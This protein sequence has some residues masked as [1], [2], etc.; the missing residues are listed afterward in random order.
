MIMNGYT[1]PIPSSCQSFSTPDPV[2]L[3][4]INDLEVQLTQLRQQIAT[5]VLSQE[6]SPPS[7]G[8][9]CLFSYIFAFQFQN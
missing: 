9:K 6:K 5:I 3:Q 2:A 1:L 8:K 7:N 4:K